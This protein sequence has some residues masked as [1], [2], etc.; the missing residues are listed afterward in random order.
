MS[1]PSLEG[2]VDVVQNWE[3]DPRR[4]ALPQ[5]ACAANAVHQ[6]QPVPRTPRARCAP[7]ADGLVGRA[8]HRGTCGRTAAPEETTDWLR[9]PRR[10]EQ[11]VDREWLTTLEG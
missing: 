11:G 6:A 5:R 7:A 2:T 3:P 4:R 10:E 9:P 1:V 8:S